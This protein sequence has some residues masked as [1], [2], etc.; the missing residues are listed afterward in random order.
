MS[1]K[2]AA[3]VNVNIYGLAGIFIAKVVVKLVQLAK[4]LLY[5]IFCHIRY[6]WIVVDFVLD[7]RGQ[8]ARFVKLNFVELVKRQL[9][10]LG[11]EL[12][13]LLLGLVFIFIFNHHGDIFGVG[14]W[15]VQQD[16][17]D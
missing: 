17:I 4:T 9:K 16:Q 5:V 11:D 2:R 1:I 8:F 6:D 3:P 14:S 10:I 12:K 7:K 13:R 15:L